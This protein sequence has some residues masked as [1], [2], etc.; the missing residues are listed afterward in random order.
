MFYYVIYIWATI[1]LKNDKHD[2]VKSDTKHKETDKDPY[3]INILIFD[4]CIMKH[5]I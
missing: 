5:Y 2:A 4:N 3:Y 1:H